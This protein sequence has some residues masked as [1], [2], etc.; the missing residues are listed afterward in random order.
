MLA[1]GNMAARPQTWLLL[2]ILSVP[3]PAPDLFG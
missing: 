2:A 1:M 3:P